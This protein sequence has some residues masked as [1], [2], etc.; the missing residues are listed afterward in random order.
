M[1]PTI[2]SEQRDALYHNI[3]DRLGGIGD[4]WTA[5]NNGDYNTADR[6]GR[7][8]SESLLLVLSDLG[9]GEGIGEPIE[10]RTPPDVLR[11]VLTRLRDTA[12]SHSDSLE[13]EGQESRELEQ[14]NSLVIEACRTVLAD[15]DETPG[16]RR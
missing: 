1:T 6:L 16:S 2:T 9:W 15:I 3:L 12:L 13:K 14:R 10:L 5:A 7:E 8:F 4:V 11:R